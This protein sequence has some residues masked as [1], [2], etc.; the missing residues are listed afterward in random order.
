MIQLT[1]L[2]KRRCRL[3]GTNER[4]RKERKM[5]CFADSKQKRAGVGRTSMGTDFLTGSVSHR[6]RRRPQ[7][8]RGPVSRSY[9]GHGASGSLTRAG[10]KYQGE[11]LQCPD[12]LTAVGTSSSQTPGPEPQDTRGS[13]MHGER[14]RDRH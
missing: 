7:D 5:T 4:S 2:S 12:H 1:T 13:E 11:V 6:W 10:P 3:K 9:C 8:G 14:R